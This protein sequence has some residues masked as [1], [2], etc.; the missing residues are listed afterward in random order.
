MNL[1]EVKL[2]KLLSQV[3]EKIILDDLN[4]YN[5]VT[6]SGTGDIKLREVVKGSSIKGS[7]M[8]KISAGNFIYSRLSIHNGAYGLI[9]DNLDNAIVTS[10]MPSFKICPQVLPEFLLYSLKLPFFQFQM[11][12]LTKGVGRTRVKEDA[13]LSFKMQ[14]PNLD[15]QN[16]I[17][18]KLKKA[19]SIYLNFQNELPLQKKLLSQIK[20]V[21][22]Q[23]AIQGK[24]T[25]TWRKSYPELISGTN[26]AENLLKQIKTEKERL[27]KDGKI[28]KEK[29]LPPIAKEEIPFELPK[30]WI[31]CRLGD[32]FEIV[33]G[34]SPRPK[35]DPRYWANKRTEHHW[36]KIADFKPFNEDGFLTDTKEFLTDEGIKHGRK[37]EKTDLIIACSGVGS[38]GKSIKMGI[39]GYIYDGLLAIRNLHSSI[40]RD[41]LSVFIKYKEIEIYSIATG[42]NWLNINTDL[43]KNYIL[44]LPPQN[45]MELIL[46]KIDLINLKC[47]ALEEEIIQSET[48]AQML[49]QAV[50]KEAFE[51]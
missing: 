16:K 34:S 47:Q 18:K 8:F 40:I 38:V 33:R 10:E 51:G 35:G 12:Q 32:L 49:M 50:L 19:E 48:N 21:I 24:L 9:P 30:G 26:A 37:V 20:Q 17:L 4:E 31:W 11:E 45:E 41:Y 25:E 27:A 39:E 28:K 6:I 22:L 29:P 44:P 36:I 14:L 2:S 43:L 3:K 7:S 15:E 46:E 42:A 1:K 13:F 23:N 5:L